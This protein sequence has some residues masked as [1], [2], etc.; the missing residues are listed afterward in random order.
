MDYVIQIV[1]NNGRQRSLAGG[2]WQ[3]ERNSELAHV[4]PNRQEEIRSFDGAV[5]SIEVEEA[6]GSAMLDIQ[7]GE[8]YLDFE[9]TKGNGPREPD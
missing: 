8:G 2:R 4:G 3:R 1:E 6:R 9:T 5:V 7:D